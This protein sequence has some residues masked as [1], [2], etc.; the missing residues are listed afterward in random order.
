M[1][2]HSQTLMPL[3][4]DLLQC[5]QLD[6]SAVD[7]FAVAAGPGSFTG[8]RIGIAAVKGLA[9]AAGKPCI[10]I[11]TLEALGY[12]LLGFSGVGCAVMDARRN[13]VYNALFSLDGSVRRLCQDRAISLADLAAELKQQPNPIILV[14]DGASLCYNELKQQLPQ[15][16]LAPEA[17]RNQRA[18]SV[19]FCAQQKAAAGV[20]TAP[21]AL[22]PSY[23]RPS[24]AERLRQ[25]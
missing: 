9:Q 11:S 7:A 3:L 2:G 6:L 15:L 16:R 8:L 22:M 1:R 12:N 10:P 20:F 14:G 18:A 17:L 23:L 24:Q 13:Q 19:A 4:Q 25:K 21:A 5:A